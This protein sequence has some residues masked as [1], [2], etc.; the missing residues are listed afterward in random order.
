M[1]K[2]TFVVAFACTG[3]VSAQNILT[4]SSF[5]DNIDNWQLNTFNEGM[6]ELSHITDDGQG[7]DDDASL[8]IQVQAIGNVPPTVSVRQNNLTL[9]DGEN[10]TVIAY[11]KSDA[12][13]ANRMVRIQAFSQGANTGA[14]TSTEFIQTYGENISFTADN[15]WQQVIGTFDADGNAMRNNQTIDLDGGIAL[16]FGFAF[17][18]QIGSYRLDNIVLAQTSTLSTQSFDNSKFI[19]FSNNNIFNIN[20]TEKIS[21]VEI[22]NLAGQLIQ[23]T[24]PNDYVVSLDNNDLSSGIYLVKVSTDK[25][26]GLFKV[27]R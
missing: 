2:I 25:A 7:D 24:N 10:Y 11:V 19:T 3:L 4:N 14:D 22:Y 26:S 9:L 17:E 8:Q 16:Q 21:S 12:Q 13:G 23:A 15:T 27:V 1:K 18:G 20:A 5:T 6:G